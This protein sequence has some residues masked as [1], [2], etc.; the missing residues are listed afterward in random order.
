M[1]IIAFYCKKVADSVTQ[2]CYLLQQCFTSLKDT[3]QK[4][5]KYYITL[6]L[7]LILLCVHS[8]HNT[9]TTRLRTWGDD[10][11]EY[12]ISVAYEK[13]E[14]LSWTEFQI[15]YKGRYHRDPPPCLKRM[16]DLALARPICTALLSVG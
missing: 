8:F 10:D 12:K 7:I 15:A 11:L 9:Y 5:R 1:S 13:P 3:P 14:E 4:Y 2:K 6:P 16:H